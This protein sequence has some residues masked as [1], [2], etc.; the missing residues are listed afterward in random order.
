MALVT[1]TRLLASHHTLTVRSFASTVGKGIETPTIA[2][3]HASTALLLIAVLMLDSLRLV[4]VV[5]LTL[6]LHAALSR[7]NVKKGKSAE[8]LGTCTAHQLIIDGS[9]TSAILYAARHAE[10]LPAMEGIIVC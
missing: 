7:I 4:P 2:R 6:L 3:V 5:T 8:T 10:N 1:S 9:I